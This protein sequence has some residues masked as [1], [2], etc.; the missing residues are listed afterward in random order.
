MSFPF[1]SVRSRYGQ[2]KL[3]RPGK[4]CCICTDI[5]LKY[6]NFFSC[7]S[8]WI[9]M[10]ACNST[11]V[12]LLSSQPQLMITLGRSAVT[13]TMQSQHEG[14]TW[15]FRTVWSYILNY[16]YPET[17]LT[18][19]LVFNSCSV[20]TVHFLAIIHTSHATALHLLKGLKRTSFPFTVFSSSPFALLPPFD[21][22][23]QQEVGTMDLK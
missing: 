3:E 17:F 13:V 1:L 2:T 4:F 6:C 21:L 7:N 14:E 8:T 16:I 5:L 18:F 15:V 10:K 23:P 19:D 12:G 22:W 20:C 11:W 9:C